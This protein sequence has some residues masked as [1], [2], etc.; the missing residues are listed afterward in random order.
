MTVA[1]HPIPMQRASGAGRIDVRAGAAAADLVSLAQS[2]SAKIRFCRTDDSVREA[3]LINTAGGLTGGDRFGWEMVLQPGARLR[4][5]TQAC[6]KIYR[7]A[8]SEAE[9]GVSLS[10]GEGAVLEW[11][12]QETILFEG[13]RLRRRFEIDA[14]P[15][16]RL[17]AAEAVILGRQ[18]MGEGDADVVLRDRWR[19]RRAGELIFA[20]DVRLAGRGGERDGTALLGKAG[21]F[22][23]VL[24]VAED[25]E[26]RLGDLRPLL[27]ER[28]GASAFDGKLFCRFLD[29][30]GAALRR[31]LTAVIGVLRDG[32][33]TPRLWTV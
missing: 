28:G 25:A 1:A 4:A 23:S 2:G 29:T 21:A 17:L 32:R 27:G 14:A 12:P 30:D 31:R 7:S 33:A 26:A 3:V 18:A 6:E 13:A 11:L 20:D 24:L 15:G 8:G 22:A 16:A 5:V 9:V 19:V 10:L